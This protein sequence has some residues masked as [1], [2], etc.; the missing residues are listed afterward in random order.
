MINKETLV[1]KGLAKHIFMVLKKFNSEAPK[2]VTSQIFCL[3]SFHLASLIHLR[4]SQKDIPVQLCP[5]HFR[6]HVPASLHERG[7]F[8]KLRGFMIEVPKR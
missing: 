4:H 6:W 2:C 8:I 1:A 7:L 5:F 3:I